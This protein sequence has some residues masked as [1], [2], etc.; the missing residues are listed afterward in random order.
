VWS[1]LTAALRSSS[2]PGEVKG[3]ASRVDARGV[4]DAVARTLGALYDAAVGM[5][6]FVSV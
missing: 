3:A 5:P 2:L 4:D 1:R 6:A